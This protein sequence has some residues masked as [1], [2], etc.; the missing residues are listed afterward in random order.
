MFYVCPDSRVKL[1]ELLYHEIT[2]SLL[3]SI[4]SSTNAVSIMK[5]ANKTQPRRSSQKARIL[6]NR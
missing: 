1:H 6:I 3:S 2:L 4:A 5:Q